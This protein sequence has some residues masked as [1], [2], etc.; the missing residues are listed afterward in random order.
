MQRAIRGSR[1][2]R[3]DVIAKIAKSATA[4]DNPWNP[5]SVYGRPNARRRGRIE[6]YDAQSV[7]WKTHIKRKKCSFRKSACWISDCNLHSFDRH[8]LLTE[9]PPRTA[10]IASSSP[11]TTTTA[12]PTTRLRSSA[13]N[14]RCARSSGA[15]AETSTFGTSDPRASN[16]PTSR[17]HRSIAPGSFA[18]CAP[19]YTPC[20]VMFF[21]SATFKG[22][23]GIEP[24]ANPITSAWPPHRIE[25]SPL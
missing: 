6:S 23:A 10:R 14:A 5:T 11:E 16:P 7:T 4:T 1:R 9:R 15:V 19:Q 12:F 24:D 13:A 22:N 8:N 18:A 17:A 25:D 20:T 2:S 21:T 3:K